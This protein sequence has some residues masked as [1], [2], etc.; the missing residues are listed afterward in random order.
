MWVE[1]R[2][3]ISALAADLTYLL[4]RW[5][6]Y[7]LL[8]W[9]SAK[10]HFSDQRHQSIPK[11]P[12]RIRQRARAWAHTNHASLFD[13]SSRHG[14]SVP[15]SP[16]KFPTAMSLFRLGR[17]CCGLLRSGD[18]RR[19]RKQHPA[20]RDGAR[21]KAFTPQSSIPSYPPTGYSAVRP[22]AFL[23]DLL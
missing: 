5:R 6:V 12:N 17:T 19:D 11:H 22:D 8:N 18:H 4:L 16:S 15:P 1:L 7:S 9:L 2:L 14:R 3:C 23:E 10:H 21:T 13:A 20:L